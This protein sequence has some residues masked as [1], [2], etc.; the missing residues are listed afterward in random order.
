MSEADAGTDVNVAGK[1]GFKDGDL[2]QEFGYDE[3]VDFDLREDIEDLIG[4]ALLDEDDQEIVDAAILWWRENDGDLVD[5]LVDSLTT[6]GEDGVV[7]VLT[8]KSGRDGY[9][10]PAEIQEAA[11]TAGLHCTSSVAVSQDWSA[12]RLVFRKK[13]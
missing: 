3:D 8:P 11:P 13:K 5:A 1:L 10:T 4:S 2:I 12:T 7:W 6:L 9:V